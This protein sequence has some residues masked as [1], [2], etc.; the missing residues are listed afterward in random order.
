MK[1]VLSLF[2]CCIF[3]ECHAQNYFD[4]VNM[5]FA[6]TPQNNFES[7]NAKTSVEEL[8]L[9][10]NFPVEISSNVILLTGVF[11]NKTKVNLDADLPST[12]LN[13]LGLNLGF[14]KT[15]NDNWSLTFMAISKLASDKISISKDNLQL[16]FL[17]IATNKK[18]DDLK[19]RYG[20]YANTEQYGLMIVPIF[21][22]YYVSTNTK[23]EADLNLPIV[24]DINYRLGSKYWLG[25]EFNGLGTTYKLNKKSYSINGAYVAKTSNEL[26]SYLRFQLTKSLL[27]NTKVGYAVARRFDMY[28]ANDKINLALTNIYFGDERIRLNERF[29]DGAIF[30]VEVLYR[31][32]F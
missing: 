31:L 13:V 6:T 14:N 22:L 30:K 16:G 32:F 28:D 3:L 21:G 24:A 25:L 27:L 2:F 4:V 11:G 5:T 1:Y 19:W 26:I 8:A 7:S 17:S 15:F 9:E 18:R 20:I 23:F 29:E 10:L 12:D